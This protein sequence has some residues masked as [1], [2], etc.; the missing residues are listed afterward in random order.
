MRLLRLFCGGEEGLWQ[1]QDRKVREQI[2]SFLLQGCG[3]SHRVTPSFKLFPMADAGYGEGGGQANPYRMD[4][5]REGRNLRPRNR[6]PGQGERR[7]FR[8]FEGG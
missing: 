3:G 6:C 2:R 4:F 5:V 7:S 8:S 1:K